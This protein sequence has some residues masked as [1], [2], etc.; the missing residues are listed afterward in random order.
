MGSITF[1]WQQR[2]TEGALTLFAGF[3]TFQSVNLAA[4]SFEHTSRAAICFSQSRQCHIFRRTQWE[5][6]NRLEKSVA[7]RNTKSTSVIRL[8]E[9]PILYL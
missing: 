9:H 2:C 6:S 5:L 8:E 4:A 1:H 7:Q 3:N